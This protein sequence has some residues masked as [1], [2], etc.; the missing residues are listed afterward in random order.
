MSQLI[1]CPDCKKHLQVPDELIGKLVQCPECKQTFTAEESTPTKVVPTSV[2]VPKQTGKPKGAGAKTKPGWEEDA[3]E[4]ES[5]SKPTAK[6]RRDYDE[7]E[8]DDDR[9]RKR[10]RRNDDED[11]DDDDIDLRRRSRRRSGERPGKV[12]A[13]AIMMLLG[14]IYAIFLAVVTTLASGFGCCLW[15]GIYYSI[16]MGI[17]A[18]VKSTSLLGDKAHLSTPPTGMGVMMIINIINVDIIN[19]VLGILIL[20]FSSDDEVVD[21]MRG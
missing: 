4:E 16:V 15:P 7:D 9:D 3:D 18:I 2:P 13:I 12:Q 17:L 10:R 6:K 5:K 19:L 21:Y 14:G 8:D 20:V 11:D 1:T